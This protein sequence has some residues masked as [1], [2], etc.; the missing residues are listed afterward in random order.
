ML[1]LVNQGVPA[2]VVGFSD[3]VETV[4]NHVKRHCR[5]NAAL[6]DYN[7]DL[8]M[9][10]DDFG[11]VF[12]YKRM[13]VTLSTDVPRFKVLLFTGLDGLNRV[14]Q[15]GMELHWYGHCLVMSFE[16]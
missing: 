12:R 5:N 8:W 16:D 9:P 1:K 3:Y 2:L 4:V 11:A 15:R 6:R 10:N 7:I 13:A 14:C